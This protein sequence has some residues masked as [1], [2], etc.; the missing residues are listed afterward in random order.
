MLRVNDGIPVVGRDDD[1]EGVGGEGVGGE[2]VGGEG[3]EGGD[4][5]MYIL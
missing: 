2:G 4:D 1:G 3:G 5:C